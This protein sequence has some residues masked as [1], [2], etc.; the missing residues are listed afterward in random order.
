MACSTTRRASSLIPA[1]GAPTMTAVVESAS[2][3]PK[4]DSSGVI[5]QGNSPRRAARAAARAASGSGGGSAVRLRPP[6]PTSQT[7]R[8][9]SRR[10]SSSTAPCP[11]PRA[12]SWSS[13]R[14]RVSCSRTLA[15]WVW[16]WARID[17]PIVL[18]DRSSGTSTSGSPDSRHASTSPSGT[19][20]LKLLT[21]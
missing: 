21:P 12:R 20:G 17:S 11:S 9:V 3:T 4:A 1:S 19:T 7:G 15:T 16:L 8:R 6:G 5:A 10:S 2:T 14:S 13:R 18:N